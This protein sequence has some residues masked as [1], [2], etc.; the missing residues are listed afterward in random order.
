MTEP[1]TWQAADPSQDFAVPSPYL[2]AKRIPEDLPFTVR[3]WKKMAAFFGGCL[4]MSPAMS[5][6]GLAINLPEL[7]SSEGAGSPG[8]TLAMLLCALVGAPLYGGGMAYTMASGGPLMA[9]DEHGVWIRVRKFPAKSIHLP[10]NSVYHVYVR[11][12]VFSR[13]VCIVP[14]DPQAGAGLGVWANADQAL[15]K[16]LTGAKLTVPTQISDR[17]AFEICQAIAYYSS[18][19]FRPQ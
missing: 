11:K 19:R 18:G 5:F 6:I 9:C 8:L 13:L 16:L 3:P 14:L 1:A 17:Y 7:T 2:R 4:G 12:W 10:W 15:A